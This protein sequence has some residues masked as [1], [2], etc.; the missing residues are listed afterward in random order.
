MRVVGV[1]GHAWNEEN[2][3][4]QVA[5]VAA[6][7]Q[8]QVHQLI[9]L[10][11]GAEVRRGRLQEAHAGGDFERLLHLPDFERG[12]ESDRLRDVHLDVAVQIAPEARHFDGD[13][14]YAHRQALENVVSRFVGGRFVC[15]LR[16]RVGG[17]Y[18]R[19][20]HAG[21]RWIEDPASDSAQGRLRPHGRNQEQEEGSSDKAAS[22]HEKT[23]EAAR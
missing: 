15:Q 4:L 7:K 11:G 1:A 22:F 14:I 16:P 10:D 17:G 8:R 6:D 9:A 12:I 5:D 2:E 23:P 19:G 21:A 18:G 3:L 13:F 20:R